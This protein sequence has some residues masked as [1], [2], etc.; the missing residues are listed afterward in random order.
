MDALRK[1]KDAVGE[2]A[3]Q[4]A[5]AAYI[6]SASSPGIESSQ[7]VQVCGSSTALCAL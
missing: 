3:R 6:P 1:E 5:A 7:L 2:T 4:I